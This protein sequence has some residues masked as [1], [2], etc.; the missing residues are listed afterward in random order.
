[1]NKNKYWYKTTINFCPV[2]G[3]ESKTKERQYVFP[4]PLNTIV[5][6]QV[7]DWCDI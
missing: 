6:K 7:Y 3:R 2:C 1:M 5:F 4:K